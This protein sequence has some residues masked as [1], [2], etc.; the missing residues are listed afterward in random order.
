[1]TLIGD[2]GALL[3]LYD[4]DDDYHNAVLSVIEKTSTII[5]PD[6]ILAEID[7]LLCK[8]LGVKAELDFL[9]ALIDGT[10]TLYRLDNQ[11]LRRCQELILQYQDLDLGL[12]DTSVMATAER[13]NI[14]NILT[15][16]ERDFRAVHLRKPLVLL[17]M[18][19]D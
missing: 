17:P 14:Y 3:A 4:K 5:I 13:L 6:M 1:M 2:T 8:F 9:E 12:A 16:D 15:L 11:D 18:D 10:Y 19:A 7:Y